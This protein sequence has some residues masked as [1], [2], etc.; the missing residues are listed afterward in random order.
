MKLRYP[1]L[2]V[3]VLFPALFSS[4]AFGDPDSLSSAEWFAMPVIHRTA[5]VENAIGELR[6]LR[7]PVGQ[8]TND[9][10]NAISDQYIRK[11]DLVVSTV[12]LL[13]SL[14]YLSEPQSQEKIETL[15]AYHKIEVIPLEGPDQ[16]VR[17]KTMRLESMARAEEAKKFQ[18]RERRGTQKNN[19][20][21]NVKKNP[22]HPA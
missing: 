15:M 18:K 14:I 21:A 9:Y 11:P 16:F 4:P 6:A 8:S 20:T 5:S 17:Y 13:P 1:A 12:V 22:K 10:V 19:F 3:F 2:F 7:V